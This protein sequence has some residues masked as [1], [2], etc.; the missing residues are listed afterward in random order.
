LNTK[1]TFKYLSAVV[2]AVLA[3][4]ITP[5]LHASSICPTPFSLTNPALD[6]ASGGNT[7]SPTYLADI[8]GAANST[9]NVLIVFN[10]DGSIT[11]SHPN[12]APYYDSGMDDN[13]VGILNLTGAPIT[14]IALSSAT[15]D[16]FAFDGDGICGS[17]VWATGTTPCGTNQGGTGTNNYN[18]AGITSMETNS[19]G[20][21]GIVNFGGGGIA[22]NGGSAF[23]SL[24]DPVADNL[25]VNPTPEPSSLLLFGT[26]IAGFA[27]VLRRKF[28]K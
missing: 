2:S 3:L 11:T 10:A 27:G 7:L 28:S 8:S 19:S 5:A 4:T 22:A 17:F 12:A 18:P 14:S 25:V 9:C 1:I 23:F 26:G 20:S 24:E 15:Q 13:L 6:G 21:A 16:P